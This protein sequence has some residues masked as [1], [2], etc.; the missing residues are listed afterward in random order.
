MGRI[1]PFRTDILVTVGISAT[2]LLLAW[3]CLGM[4]PLFAISE[5]AYAQDG[6]IFRY[7]D[8]NGRTVYTNLEG[9]A[10]HGT[11]LTRLELPPLSSVDFEHAK[12]EELR[13][14]DAHV[15]DSHS[16]LQSGELC[17]SIRK[18]SRSAL[19]SR[20]WDDHG[21]KISVAGGLLVF[22]ALLGFVGAGRK[23]GSLWPLPPIAGCLFLGYATWRDVQAAREA[24]TAGLRACSEQLPD[25]EPDDKVAVQGRLGKALDLQNIVNNTY[26]RQSAEIE[27]IMRER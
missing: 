5:R 14:L 15:R 17:E 1:F 10:S 23:F 8:R 16:A 24:L 19:R 12:P 20:L 13:S 2:G 22:A 18:A 26:E 3:F 11:A 9:S 7:R 25:G 21:R 6:G 27:A 4:A